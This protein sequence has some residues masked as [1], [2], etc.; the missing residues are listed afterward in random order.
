LLAGLT[1]DSIKNQ[2]KTQKSCLLFTDQMPVN[3]NILTKLQG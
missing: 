2:I 3:N 1:F